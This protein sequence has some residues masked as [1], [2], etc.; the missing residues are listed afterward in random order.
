[1]PVLLLAAPGLAVLGG[2][3]AHAPEVD[4]GVEPRVGVEEDVAALAAVAPVG[5]ALG[6]VLA[7]VEGDAAVPA[8]AGLNDDGD[9]VDEHGGQ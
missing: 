7:A 1:V 4:E 2:P 6:D 8:V 3:V 5:P 9:L